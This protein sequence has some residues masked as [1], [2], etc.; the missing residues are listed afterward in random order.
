MKRNSLIAVLIASALAGGCAVRGGAY[1][2]GYSGSASGELVYVS[3]GV[4]A[5]ADYDRPVFYHGDAYWM[6]QDGAWYQSGYY[7]GGWVRARAVPRAVLTIERPRAYI[8]W[9]GDG[10]TRIRARDHRPHRPH[11][12]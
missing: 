8:H 1:T 6:Y 12:Y 5:V 7:T 4:Y 9:R 10:R 11:R 3:P 2:T